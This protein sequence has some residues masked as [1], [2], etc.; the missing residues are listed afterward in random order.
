MFRRSGNLN[1]LININVCPSPG[2]WSPYGPSPAVSPAH[3]TAPSTPASPLSPE[4]P[5]LVSASQSEKKP[6][7]PV[8]A[9]NTPSRLTPTTK[10]KERVKESRSANKTPKRPTTA[11]SKERTSL[12]VI[13][14]K[15]TTFRKSKSSDACS[16]KPSK[17][18]RNQHIH[19]NV[20]STKCLPKQARSQK[21]AVQSS[22]NV[23]RGSG[24]KSNVK[25]KGPLRK[26]NS[27]RKGARGKK[28][29]SKI[30]Q[31]IPSEVEATYFKDPSGDD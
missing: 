27:P 24:T 22:S 26:G 8:K 29:N 17:S 5:I 11:R 30:K 3:S 1:E 16:S 21:K 23:R 15:R 13:S 31:K 28:K 14:P 2:R 20:K 18:S 9:L 6:T 4:L 19:Y 7:P 25:R 10:Q 12:K